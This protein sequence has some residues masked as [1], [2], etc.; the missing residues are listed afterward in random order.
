M[1][2]TRI[3]VSVRKKP[4]SYSTL[5]E[6]AVNCNCVSL[7]VLPEAVHVDADR[8]ACE[9]HEHDGRRPRERPALL[10]A[11]DDERRLD[12]RHVGSS[13]R[14]PVGIRGR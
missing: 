14:I 6:P 11:Q 9:L 1:G 7:Q 10:Q 5:E 4:L 8:E 13:G 12:Q 3:L 2:T